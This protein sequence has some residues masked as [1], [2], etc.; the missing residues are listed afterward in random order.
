MNNPFFLFKLGLYSAF[1]LR[2]TSYES[3]VLEEDQ[4]KNSILSWVKENYKKYSIL[5]YIISNPNTLDSLSNAYFLFQVASLG[6][7]GRQKLWYL[8]DAGSG[9]TQIKNKHYDTCL[10]FAG[11]GQEIRADPCTNGADQQWSLVKLSQ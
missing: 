3:F 6:Q 1:Q 2:P 4:S 8:F 10:T 11:L 5:Q 7:F 9:F